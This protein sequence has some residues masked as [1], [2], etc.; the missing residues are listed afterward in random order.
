[1]ILLRTRE[2]WANK[3]IENYKSMV[4]KITP[5]K[6]TTS[7]GLIVGNMDNKIYILAT[8]HSVKKHKVFEIN[9]HGRLETVKAPKFDKVNESL[10]LAILVLNP[11]SQTTLFEPLRVLKIRDLER[12]RYGEGVWLL[13]HPGSRS[14]LANTNVNV[15]EDSTDLSDTR[16]FNISNQGIVEGYSGGPVFDNNYNLLGIVSH[17]GPFVEVIRIMHIIRQLSI[18]GIPFNQLLISPSD[19]TNDIMLNDNH[20]YLDKYL[21]SKLA[22]K[23]KIEDEFRRILSN[24]Q[25]HISNLEKINSWKKF[26]E[27]FPNNYKKEEVLKRISQLEL[28]ETEFGFNK[29]LRQIKKI[30]NLEIQLIPIKEKLDVLEKFRNKYKKDFSDSVLFKYVNN[31]LTFWKLM[32]EYFKNGTSKLTKYFTMSYISGGTFK[33][34]AN[35]KKGFKSCQEYRASEKLFFYDC[36]IQWFDDEFP[37]YVEVDSFFMDK[38]EVSQELYKKVMGENRNPSSISGDNQPVDSIRWDEANEFCREVG[39]RLPTEAE[40]EIAIRGKSKNNFFWGDEF[41]PKWANSCDKNCSQKNELIEFDD[42]FAYSS[43]IGTFLPNENGLFDMAGN[44]FEWVS[45]Y[46]DKQYYNNSNGLKNPQGP[47]IEG[48]PKIQPDPKFN[49]Y[50]FDELIFTKKVIRGGSWL[51]LPDALRVANRDWLNPMARALDVGFRCAVGLP[52]KN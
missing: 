48:F 41:D 9:F 7:A 14:W 23:E 19:V 13:G 50:H 16:I 25:S 17:I 33:I 24:E 15:I 5:D 40:W 45:D 21:E 35:S 38:Y 43:P 47:S 3:K 11:V 37:H 4:V 31:R 42:G 36:E 28:K 30:D 49:L 8:Y 32:D 6:G 12:S 51:T 39:K 2:G 46:Y 29:E 22:Q 26:L 10:D 1:M 52:N 27:D 20:D 34:G 44:V 18:W